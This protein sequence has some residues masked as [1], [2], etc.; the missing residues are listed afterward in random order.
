MQ[1]ERKTKDLGTNKLQRNKRFG[2]KQIIKKL[3]IWVKTNYKETKV[4]GTNKL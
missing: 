2:Y 4:L 1:D 3:K